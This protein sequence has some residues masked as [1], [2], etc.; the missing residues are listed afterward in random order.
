MSWFSGAKTILLREGPRSKMTKTP[1]LLRPEENH[2]AN[3]HDAAFPNGRLICS[4]CRGA[5]FC[6]DR[7]VQENMVAGHRQLCSKYSIE[8]KN[9]PAGGQRAF[10]FPG[11]MSRA[12]IVFVDRLGWRGQ[13]VERR[14]EFFGEAAVSTMT[15]ITAEYNYMTGRRLPFDLKVVKTS[16]DANVLANRSLVSSFVS[17]NDAGFVPQYPWTNGVLVVRCQ[18]GTDVA[19]DVTMADYRDVMDFFTW[20]GH[21][22]HTALN[23][24]MNA[25]ALPQQPAVRGV[26]IRCDASISDLG[27][28]QPPVSSLMIDHLHPIRG[29]YGPKAGTLSLASA[30]VGVPLRLFKLPPPILTRMNSWHKISPMGGTNSRARCLMMNVS[31]KTPIEF[32]SL[33]AEY[34]NDHVGD[35]LVARDDGQDLGEDEVR[36]LVKMMGGWTSV[37]PWT[38]PALT[39]EMQSPTGQPITQH[40]VESF[41]TKSVYDTYLFGERQ[42]ATPPPPPPADS[43]ERAV[44]IMDQTIPALHMRVCDIFGQPIFEGYPYSSTTSVMPDP[45]AFVRPLLA[46]VPGAAPLSTIATPFSSSSSSSSSSSV[47]GPGPANPP[48]TAPANP[49]VAPNGV[50]VPPL[51]PVAKSASRR[52]RSVSPKKAAGEAAAPPAPSSRPPPPTFAPAPEPR[53]VPAVGITAVDPSASPVIAPRPPVLVTPTQ[54]FA[55]P[56]AIISTPASCAGSPRAGNSN[57][58]AMKGVLKRRPGETSGSRPQSPL[59]NTAAACPANTAAAPPPANTNASSSSSPQKKR[60][61][62]APHPE[63]A[64]P[65]VFRAVSVSPPPRFSLSPDDP[66]NEEFAAV[67]SGSATATSGGKAA[68]KRGCPADGFSEHSERASKRWRSPGHVPDMLQDGGGECRA[69]FEYPPPPR[70]MYNCS[71]VEMPNEWVPGGFEVFLCDEE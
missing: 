38:W 14:G 27:P 43:P 2:C 20:Y 67:G 31:G 68:L 66:L 40:I 18:T 52:S 32:G 11:T 41:V 65:P 57:D 47:V 62:F 61:T 36:A 9:R 13:L 71:T 10:F 7:C 26:V 64:S 28:P 55:T 63:F 37:R 50:N 58:D 39:R 3:C 5:I 30:R 29:L 4:Q 24:Y 46:P 45:A 16:P 12:N 25:H 1:S 60:V 17:M 33:P 49:F 23:G 53:F 59:N 54:H 21:R 35:V 70:R 34:H 48:V 22:Y 56:A 8:D 6:S 42:G 69:A 19:E 15:T 44:S 51:R